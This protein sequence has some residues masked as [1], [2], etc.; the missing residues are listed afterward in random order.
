MSRVSGA[1]GLAGR[2]VALVQ[3]SLELGGAERQAILFARY[4]REVVGADASIW[5]LDRPGLA[6]EFCS[7]LGIPWRI[8]RCPLPPSAWW[9]FV[10]LL[11]FARALRR[12]RVEVLL[13]YT[14]PPNIVCGIT[15]RWAG[16]RACV[17]NQQDEGRQRQGRFWER[18]AVG[19]LRLF[20]SNSTAGAAFLRESLGV[21]T[22]RIRII[23][24]GIALP[25]R[26]DRR[27]EW[28]GRLGAGPAT[29]V[30]CMLANLHPGKDHATLVRAW[31]VVQEAWGE[32]SGPRPVLWLAGR[33]EGT[34]AEL[35]A[36]VEGASLGETVHFLG[37]VRDVPGL[38][39]AADLLVHSSVCEGCP[40][41]VQEAM[42]LGLPVV[43]TDIPGLRD[44][45][46]PAW[47]GRLAP[48]GDAAG[49]AGRMLDLL[50]DA[51]ARETV[52]KVNREWI[53]SSCDPDVVY[54]ALASAVAGAL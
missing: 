48:P 22:E 29:P 2:R 34:E 9:R 10:H 43:G 46:G 28:R 33:P 30:V 39:S 6:S 13:P 54:G 11:R 32:T 27:A 5:G 21:P 35:R 18:R 20:V 49:L 15:G 50:R 38:L 8:E 7:E 44:A 17:W 19:H 12:E 4:L 23:G 51:S 42:A 37:A 31:A 25:E 1:E 16:V 47:E 40:N 52:G 3:Q 14:M 36:W 26:V 41:A 53:R 45:L 24:N